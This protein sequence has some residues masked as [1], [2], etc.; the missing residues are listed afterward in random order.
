MYAHLF[1]GCWQAQAHSDAIP[2]FRL[3]IG[4]AL[5]QQSGFL[6]ARLLMNPTTNQCILFIFWE[7]AADRQRADA[8]PV[9][10]T[11]LGHLQPYCS[12]PLVSADYELSAQVS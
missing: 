1:E 7:T 10:Q 12:R 11:L 9:F 2:Y 3:T 8:D 4:P 5:R 6:N